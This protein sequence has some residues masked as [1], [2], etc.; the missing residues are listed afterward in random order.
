VLRRLD[1]GRTELLLSSTAA[2]GRRTALEARAELAAD[3]RLLQLEASRLGG[4]SAFAGPWWLARGALRWED[5]EGPGLLTA[6]VALRGE[7]TASLVFPRRGG[8]VLGWAE[9]G[10]DLQAERWTLRGGVQAG[11]YLPLGR[12]A[13]LWAGAAAAGARDDPR[14]IAPESEGWLTAEPD[15]RTSGLLAA[16]VEA[17]LQPMGPV[18][19]GWTAAAGR[20]AGG[21]G[22]RWQT[23]PALH[24]FGEM[25][26]ALH[27]DVPL[28]A[29]GGADE[30]FAW[31]W[32]LRIGPRV[33]Q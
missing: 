19:L 21:P 22:G 15:L 11:A 20:L 7:T 28:Y 4:R 33:A 27:L 14:R 30:G 32:A 9:A 5:G 26:F 23:G 16:R 24:L 10:R 31:R 13:V 8:S 2:L 6:R 17:L 25:P 1:S 29:E 3:S 12:Y 18:A